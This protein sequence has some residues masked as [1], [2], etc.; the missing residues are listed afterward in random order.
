[1]SYWCRE[2]RCVAEVPATTQEERSPW[3]SAPRIVQSAP[4]PAGARTET[5]ATLCAGVSL[6]N[7]CCGLSNELVVSRLSSPESDEAPKRL[8]AARAEVLT[9]RP[10]AAIGPPPFDSSAASA[11]RI[12][13]SASWST[14]RRRWRRRHAVSLRFSLARSLLRSD[15]SGEAARAPCPSGPSA[16]KPT[17]A[18]KIGAADASDEP[19][20]A[21]VRRSEISADAVAPRPT[22]ISWPGDVP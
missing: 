5:Y 19:P 4:L 8:A 15:A 6:L 14:L 13:P 7:S 10:T 16:T 18:A 12:V 2:G 22:S 1:M 3:E 11:S 20:W 9:D 17:P 21:G